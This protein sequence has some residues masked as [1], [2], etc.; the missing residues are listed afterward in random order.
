MRDDLSGS[1][2]PAVE[3]CYRHPGEETGVHCTRCGRPICTDC[4]RAAAVGY[5]C[6]D[7]VAQ[8]RSEFKLGPRR[9]PRALAGISFTKVLLVAIWVMFAV[10]MLT[11][12]RGA[13]SA[14]PS[15]LRLIDL[16]ASYPPAIASGQYWRLLTPM[17][18]HAGILHIGLNS[19]ALWLFGTAI[20]DAFGR[21]RFL[22]IYFVSGLLASVASYA[23]GPEAVG[24]GASGAVF[25]LLGAFVAHNYRRRHLAAA[26]ANLRAAL[27]IIAINV[28]L[29]FS[30]AGIDNRAHIGGLVA[31]AAAGF[32]VEGLGP[33]RLR[34][35]IRIAGFAALVAIGV[36]LTAWRTAD[37]NATF[38]GLL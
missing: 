1:A 9:R 2:A 30:V 8:A 17:F 25:G 14:G 26:A 20:E 29:G 34:P 13:L 5:Q 6:P 11:G 7:C 21:A 28:M 23:F 27:L 18:L 31:G 32:L 10:E 3:H 19:W 33:R 38:R 15:P 24:I 4:M 35:M 36:A 12:G 37:I 16:G 22:L